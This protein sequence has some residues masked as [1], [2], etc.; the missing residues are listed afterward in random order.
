MQTRVLIIVK[1]WGSSIIVNLFR[2]SKRPSFPHTNE[3]FFNANYAIRIRYIISPIALFAQNHF[4]IGV[5]KTTEK[6]VATA[7]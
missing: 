5:L 1:V 2:K 7:G 4:G 6:V 3:R